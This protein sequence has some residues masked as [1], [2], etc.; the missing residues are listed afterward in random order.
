MERATP[1]QD[2]IPLLGIRKAIADHMVAS[3]RAAAQLTISLEVDATEL[4]ALRENIVAGFEAAI[5]IR[6]TYTDLLIVLVTQAL[7]QNPVL[8]STLEGGEIILHRDINMGVAV[9]LSDGLIVPV[10]CEAQ[11]CGL[12]EITKARFN[13]ARRAEEGKLVPKDVQGGTFT[14]TNV[15]GAGADISTPI[16]NSPQNAILGVGRI[17]KKPAVFR[18]EIC[19][20]HMLWLNVTFDHRAMDGVPVA[21]FLSGLQGMVQE[22]L[23]HLGETWV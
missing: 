17:V 18:D 12:K 10:I 7:Q 2:R 3:L 5:G 13:L 20:R 15:G 1:V 23:A 9:A 11:K 14:I 8:N 4:V 19:V 21:R 22:P 6:P 16:L